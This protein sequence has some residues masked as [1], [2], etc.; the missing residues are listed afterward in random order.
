MKELTIR[1][2]C[3][4]IGEGRWQ[5]IHRHSSGGDAVCDQWVFPK[6][7]SHVLG[8]LVSHDPT[9]QVALRHK[10]PPCGGE[11]SLEQAREA[12]KAGKQVEWWC[13][14][15]VKWERLGGDWA[16]ITASV[17]DC[18]DSDYRFRLAPEIKPEQRCGNCGWG[19]SSRRADE[20]VCNAPISAADMKRV[21]KRVSRYRHMGKHE[22]ADCEAWK[23]VDR[24]CGNCG[25]AELVSGTDL[26]VGCGCPLP[27]WVEPDGHAIVQFF[28]D[29]KDC[30]CW[31]PKPEEE[32]KQ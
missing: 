12:V 24:C 23:E 25:W 21:D 3:A 29:G 10:P 19:G 30:P 1:E 17:W 13:I 9:R 15:R 16:D 11:I 5:E 26:I 32:V 20:V 14:D 22:G 8:W 31:K 6:S 4:L 18:P 7:E 2:A 27:D 28:D